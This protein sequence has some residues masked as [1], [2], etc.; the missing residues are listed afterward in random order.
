M[1]LL[2][3]KYKPKNFRPA[4]AFAGEFLIFAFIFALV[5]SGI[6]FSLNFKAYAARIIFDLGLDAKQS[7][8]SLAAALPGEEKTDEI[9]IPKIGVRA[10][11]I[12]SRSAKAKDVLEDLKSGA[13]L[14]PGSAKPGSRTGK[15]VILGHSADYVI[16]LYE[17]DYPTVFSLID[18][19][20]K[21]DEIMVV[22]NGRNFKYRVEEKFVKTPKQITTEVKDD[23]LYLMSCW[24]V[25]TDLKRIVVRAVLI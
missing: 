3:P 25:G 17:S 18:K 16:R 20:E 5:W 12:A 1:N 11:I 14:Y 15:T 23:G 9:I 6:F 19:L 24:P 13:V 7:F 21:S 2:R 8:N 4:L 10:P 22:F